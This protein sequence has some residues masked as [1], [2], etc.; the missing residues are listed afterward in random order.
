[1]RFI[2]EFLNWGNIDCRSFVN[3]SIV[4]CFEFESDC[5]ATE[6]NECSCKKDLGEFHVLKFR[7]LFYNFNIC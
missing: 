5:I 7:F 3:Y 2:K 1:M 6:S 4:L